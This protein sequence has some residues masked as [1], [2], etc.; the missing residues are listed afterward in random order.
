MNKIVNYHLSKS[1]ALAPAPGQQL[2]S[3]QD[4]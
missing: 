4:S 2:R 1:R 3:L